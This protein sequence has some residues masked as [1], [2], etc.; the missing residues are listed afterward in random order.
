MQHRSPGV[1]GLV[2]GGLMAALIVVFSMVPVLAVFMPIPLVLAYVR[3]GGRV[4]VLT[5]V[6]AALFTMAFTGFITG[7]LMI[8]G[9]ILPGLVFG[10]GFRHHWRPLT[11]G[12]VA[13]VVFFLGYAMEYSITRV[14]M[15]DGRDPIAAAFESP[16]GQKQL[17]RALDLMDQA[18]VAQNPENPTPQQLQSKEMLENLRKDPAGFAWALLPTT[19]FLLGAFVTWVNYQ[20]CRLTLPRFGHPVPPAGSFAEF[21]LPVWLIWTYGVLIFASP[22][23]ITPDIAGASWWAKL[24]LN[25]FTPLGLILALAG[26]AVVYGYFRHKE[27]S[28]GTAVLLTFLIY[29]LLGKMAMQIYVLVAMWDSIFDFRGLGHGL[30]KR[31]K[32]QI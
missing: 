19:L 1:Q 17:N 29:L 3:Y 26:F 4:A 2:F 31:P 8:P 32:E 11:I 25:I 14:A 27:L 30:W 23:F 12:I 16:A 10:Y 18:L 5:A 24:L 9:G 6:V 15:F 21:R 20:L 22:F 13:V 28:K 7:L